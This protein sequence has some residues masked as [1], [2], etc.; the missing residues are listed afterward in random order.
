MAG[1]RGVMAGLRPSHPRLTEGPLCSQLRARGRRLVRDRVRGPRRERIWNVSA[2]ILS[3]MQRY[4]SD[5]SRRS[6]I[7]PS[8]NI[9]DSCLALSGATSI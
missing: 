8:D 4:K 1:R 2:F 6:C 3:Q 9:S 7:E 5:A